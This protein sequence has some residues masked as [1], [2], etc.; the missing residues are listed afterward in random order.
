[1]NYIF[2]LANLADV[3]AA[4][5]LIAKR[6]NWMEENGIKQW[7]TT[8]YLNVYP[9]P[10]FESHQKHG[11]LYKMSEEA[12]GKLVGVMVLLDNDPRWPGN[13]LTDSYFVHNFATD[14]SINGLGSLMLLE[15]EQL[16][17]SHKKTYLRLDCPSHSMILHSYYESRGYIHVGK[18]VDGA[19][20]GNLREKKLI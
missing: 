15:A 13:N 3:P 19:Y 1:M 20:S 14:P 11:R 5:A 7:N 17:I 2:E 12:S 10:Y 4:Y 16:S 18:C 8:D 9:L 6:V